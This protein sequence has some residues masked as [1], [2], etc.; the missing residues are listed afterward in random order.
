MVPHLGKTGIK[1]QER[2]CVE[3]V[4]IQRVVIAVDVM[5]HLLG[6]LVTPNSE[7]LGGDFDECDHLSASN[8]TQYRRDSPHL[9]LTPSID[10]SHL[11]VVPPH[12]RAASD[13]VVRHPHGIVHEGVGRHGPV[14]PA[15][16]D[17]QA[18]PCASK[19]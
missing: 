7:M 11:M 3:D 8:W 18:D 5:G 9:T 6:A 4:L 1:A 2:E 19:A 10:Y 13:E 14:V 16:L 17:G 15:V 12:Q